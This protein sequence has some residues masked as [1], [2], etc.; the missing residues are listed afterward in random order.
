MPILFY[1]RTVAILSIP[2]Y[3]WFQTSEKLWLGPIAELRANINA[4][5]TNLALGFGLG[6]QVS[7]AVDL[8]TWI[9]LPAINQ[10][11]GTQFFGLGFGVQVRVE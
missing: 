11:N 6:Y 8:K 1:N 10:D 3:F 4:S 9:L 5:Q 2:G 7:N